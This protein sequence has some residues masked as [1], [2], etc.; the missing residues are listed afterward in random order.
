MDPLKISL[1]K[2]DVLEQEFVIQFTDF[3]EFMIKPTDD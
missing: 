2:G 1:F 3:H